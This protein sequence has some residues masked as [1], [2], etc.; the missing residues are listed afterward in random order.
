M[1]LCILGAYSLLTVQGKLI[2]EGVLVSCYASFPDHDMAHFAMSPIRWFPEVMDWM[3]GKEKESPVY[4]GILKT[5]ANGFSLTSECTKEV[6]LCVHKISFNYLIRIL[7]L[8][9]K[10]FIC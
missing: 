4:V 3:F 2:V 8:L 6:I 9:L 10:N 5:L 7:Y 1:H